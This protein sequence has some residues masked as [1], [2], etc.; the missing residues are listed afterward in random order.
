MKNIFKS[1]FPKKVKTQ[2]EID[3]ESDVQLIESE[4]P[5]ISSQLLRHGVHRVTDDM[6][7]RIKELETK[8]K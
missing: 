7:R 8:N 6:I 1:L 4:Y 5:G 3:N 2:A